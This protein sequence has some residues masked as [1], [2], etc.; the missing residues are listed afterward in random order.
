MFQWKNRELIHPPETK[1]YEWGYVWGTTISDG[2]VYRRLNKEYIRLSVTDQ[3][4]VRL[5]RDCVGHITGVIYKILGPY[6]KNY[7]VV[8]TCPPLVNRLT[9][10][11]SIGS[12][13]WEV[14]N[15]AFHNNG[16][17][18]GFLNG[19]L[20]GDGSPSEDCRYNPRISWT[21]VNSTGLGQVCDL[22]DR[23]G[24]RSTLCPIYA[25]DWYTLTIS[26][27]NDN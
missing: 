2:S 17:A 13:Q 11:F 9:A 6:G 18:R 24:I 15:E 5:F 26:R 14:P 8:V 19:Y 27:W 25:G 22:L 1:P 7:I 20:D 16:V 23:F 3:E 4:F 12:Y 10:Y 21:S